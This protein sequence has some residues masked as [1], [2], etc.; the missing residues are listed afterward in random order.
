MEAC[1]GWKNWS[2]ESATG[3]TILGREAFE[4]ELSPSSMTSEC[5]KAKG[6]I[7][8][9]RI[10]VI[11]TP[12]L[13]DTKFT[14]EE[15]IKRIKGCISLSSPGPH[16]FVICLQIGR[17][18]QEEKDTIKLIQQTFGEEAA[19]FTVVLFTHGDKLRRHTIESFIRANDDLSALIQMC[20][21]RY[22]VFNNEIKD[23]K[24][25]EELLDKIKQMI[26]MNGG[27]F[28]THEMFRSA[29]EA[30]EKEKERLLKES[31][32]QRK[33]ELK[34]LFAQY[35]EDKEMYREK[36]KELLEG[37]NNDARMRAEKSNEFTRSPGALQSLGMMI[38][39][40]G[41]KLGAAIGAGVGAVVGE[42]LEKACIQQ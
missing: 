26:E 19:K 15:I 34:Q 2:R 7:G 22:H 6:S 31:E 5:Q 23:E 25:V 17:F 42:T 38:G 21:N 24:Q 18:T 41:G 14:Q 27:G 13:Y 20:H 36:E 8:D 33:T 32:E 29:E 10:A 9:Q 35:A 12:G 28:Y 11:D 16:S 3:N 30:I 39:S 40:V 37:Y 4:S 1:F